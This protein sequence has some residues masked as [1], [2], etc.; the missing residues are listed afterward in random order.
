MH[1]LLSLLFET[2]PLYID[3][4]S[5]FAVHN[6]LRIIAASP[7]ASEYLS[8]FIKSLRQESTKSGIAPGNA[9]VLTEWCAIL[10]EE[11]V[12]QPSIWNKWGL[13]VVRADAS[14]LDICVGSG[15]RHSLKHSALVVA[16]RGLRRVLKTELGQKSL[17]PIVSALTSKGAAPTA[18]NAVFL[19]V[20]AGVAARLPVLEAAFAKLKPDYFAFYIR[21]IL[22]SKIVLPQHIAEALDDFFSSFVEMEDLQKE[23]L[24]AV[25]KALL[26]SPEVVLNDLIA[27]LVKALPQNMDLSNVLQKSLMKP[28]MSNIKSTNATIR[29]GALRTFQDI[30]AKSSDEA[31]IDK[32]ADEIVNPLKQNKVPAADQKVLH[33][34]MLASLKQSGSLSKK[35]PSALVAVAL[36]EA[37]ETALEAELHAITHHMLHGLDNG[38]APEPSVQD[39]FVKGIADKRPNV[40]RVWALQF[41]NLL[42]RMDADLKHNDPSAESFALAVLIKM[43]DVFNEVVINP[44][45][46][47]QNGLVTVAYIFTFFCLS[48]LRGSNDQKVSALLKKAS[49][50]KHA[51]IAEPKPSFLLNF[52]V[53]SKITGQDD[54]TWA[55]RSLAAVAE[56]IAHG[57]ANPAVEDAWSQA[58]LYFITA[59]NMPQ[60]IRKDA[61][62]TLSQLYANSPARIG[63][64]IVSGIWQWRRNVDLGEKDSAALAAK[65]GN[66]NL[67]LAIRAICFTTEMVTEFKAVAL[68][69]DPSILHDQM[70]Q[71]LVLCHEELVPRTSWIDTCLRVSLDPGK[72]VAD[73]ADKCLKEIIKTTEVRGIKPQQ[74]R[75]R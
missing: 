25:E 18:R 63:S 69:E 6:C 64:I 62:Q 45:P 46:S 60:A 12:K 34:K 26:R 52:R 16:R 14:A 71:L 41:G 17:G 11:F 7:K 13:E 53:Y 55:I 28:L 73:N 42:W 3:R 31:A 15:A 58:F 4:N 49:I 29:D 32:I 36:K 10:L 5:R 23:L 65:T 72:L 21:E 51:L 19:G 8:G 61:A 75:K 54:L 35:I 9:F 38:T 37:N 39:A 24:P 27:P 50:Q 67:F 59:A 47:A 57:L 1:L 66:D 56:D 43:A 20:V 2:Y 68:E 44:L 30:A 22:G 74:A 48:R 33:A 70:I 40:R